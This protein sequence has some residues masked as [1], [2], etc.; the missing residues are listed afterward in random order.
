MFWATKIT[1]SRIL[2][3]RR[4][5]RGGKGRNWNPTNQAH[6]HVQKHSNEIINKTTEKCGWEKW[7]RNFSII[8]L[9]SLFAKQKLEVSEE[10]NLGLPVKKSGM[11][12]NEIKPILIWYSESVWRSKGK[13]W[14]SRQWREMKKDENYIGGKNLKYIYVVMGSMIKRSKVYINA[15]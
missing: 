1:I 7:F 4:G 12:R 11:R 14:V 10:N 2:I 6:I 8:I 5:R 3:V 9:R 15:S 13:K